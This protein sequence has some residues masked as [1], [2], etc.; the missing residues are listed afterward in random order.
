MSAFRLNLILVLCFDSI[1]RTDGPKIMK[2][3]ASESDITYVI[4]QIN[5]ADQEKLC[6]QLELDCL[7]EEN[8]TFDKLDGLKVLRRWRVKQGKAATRNKLVLALEKTNAKV[9][10]DVAKQWQGTF[11]MV[12]SP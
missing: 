10:K 2:I 8:E 3:E 7:Y 11:D 6:T 9:G 4:K 5:K 12:P 1:T